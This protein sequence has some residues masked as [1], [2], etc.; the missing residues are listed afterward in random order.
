MVRTVYSVC[1]ELQKNEVFVDKYSSTDCEG[2]FYFG[3][4]RLRNFFVYETKQQHSVFCYE[5]IFILQLWNEICEIVPKI[6]KYNK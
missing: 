5:S 3:R 6:E 1:L 4:G 2:E